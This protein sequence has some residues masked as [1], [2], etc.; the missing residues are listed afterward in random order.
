MTLGFDL[1]YLFLIPLALGLVFM[2]W[3]LWNL[4]KQLNR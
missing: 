4:T 2:V 1:A 3:V